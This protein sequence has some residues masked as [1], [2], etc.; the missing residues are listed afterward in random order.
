MRTITDS[1]YNQPPTTA[2]Q[3]YSA[4][5]PMSVYRELAAELQATQEAIHPLTQQNAH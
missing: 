1:A 4:S 5:V 2:N 3:A